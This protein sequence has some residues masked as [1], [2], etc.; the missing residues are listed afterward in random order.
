MWNATKISQLHMVQSVLPNDTYPH[1]RCGF[2][3]LCRSNLLS[4]VSLA[5]LH[6]C[7]C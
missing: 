6:S 4:A 1:T 2:Q 7:C 5:L 3:L